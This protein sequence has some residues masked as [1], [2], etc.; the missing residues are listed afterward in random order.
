MESIM[1]YVFHFGILGIFVWVCWES[2][3]ISEENRRNEFTHIDLYRKCI[4]D[5]NKGRKNESND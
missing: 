2:Y 3:K 4:R 5:I 1:V